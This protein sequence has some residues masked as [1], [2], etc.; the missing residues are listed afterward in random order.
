MLEVTDDTSL[1]T[2]VR[3][4]LQIETAASKSR[5]GRLLKLADKTSNLCA[6]AVSPPQGWDTVRLAAY[7]RLAEQ[8]V[9]SCRGLNAELERTF[10]MAAA[11]ARAAIL[12][13]DPHID[14]AFRDLP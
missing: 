1:P 13:L 10:D 3:K 6:L 5:D 7:V 8:V 9:A 12:V 2:E 14:P 11:A 4:R